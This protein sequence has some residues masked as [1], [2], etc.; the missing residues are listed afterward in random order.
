MAATADVDGEKLGEA[1]KRFAAAAE[2]G[3]AICR[4]VRKH[5]AQGARAADEAVHEHPYQV[6]A[7]GLVVGEFIDYLVARRCAGTRTGLS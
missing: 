2:S 6:I 3:K 1:R 5:A 4:R 7:I